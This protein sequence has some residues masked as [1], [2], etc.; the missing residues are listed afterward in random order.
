MTDVLGNILA[1]SLELPVNIAAK[2]KPTY[3][4]SILKERFTIIFAPSLSLWFF[5]FPFSCLGFFVCV[6]HY[7]LSTHFFPLNENVLMSV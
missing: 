5:V 1:R 3:I 6:S 4:A 7:T 2:I